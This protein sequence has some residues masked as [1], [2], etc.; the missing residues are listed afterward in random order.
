MLGMVMIEI[1]V[2]AVILMMPVM[3]MMM[4]MMMITASVEFTS[5]IPSELRSTYESCTTLPQPRA[6]WHFQRGRLHN[7]TYS[8]I[9]RIFSYVSS[10]NH[11]RYWLIC[12][13]IVAIP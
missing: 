2:T 6:F 8:K 4:M 9:F 13:A 12:W 10:S 11:I 1:I 5:V 3:M 7:S